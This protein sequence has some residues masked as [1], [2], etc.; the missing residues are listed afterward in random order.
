MYSP[1]GYFFEIILLLHPIDI[2]FLSRQA[3]MHTDLV[4]WELAGCGL[5]CVGG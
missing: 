1:I 2:I 5:D 3:G 4:L